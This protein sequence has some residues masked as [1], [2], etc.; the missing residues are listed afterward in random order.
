[1]KCLHGPKN[2]NQGI[3]PQLDLLCCNGHRQPHSELGSALTSARCAGSATNVSSVL[4][5]APRATSATN[6]AN[7][8]GLY[9]YK[10]TRQ[11]NVQQ[12]SR[13]EMASQQFAMKSYACTFLFTQTG[14]SSEQQYHLPTA[15]AKLRYFLNRATALCRWFCICLNVSIPSLSTCQALLYGGPLAFCNWIIA[16]NGHSWLSD[17]GTSFWRSPDTWWSFPANKPHL[18][19]WRWQTN[20]TTIRL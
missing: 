11:R 7:A 10:I 18:T 3:E 20:D 14:T 12:N 4:H 9:Q 17:W 2:I 8:L 19:A 16:T 5:T 1:M 6:W 13:A 15:L